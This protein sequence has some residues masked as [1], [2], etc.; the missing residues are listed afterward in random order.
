M[1]GGNQVMT[2]VEQNTLKRRG[3][4]LKTFDPERACPGL[5]LFAPL[6]VE[7]RTVYLIDLQGKLDHTR[8]MPYSPGLS[9]Y[10]TER[11][12]LYYNGRNPEDNYLSRLL[13]KA[14]VA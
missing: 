14:G 3:V 2:A 9:G 11:G 8:K 13:I 7:S 4:G 5:T 12:R 6:F 1:I 10:L